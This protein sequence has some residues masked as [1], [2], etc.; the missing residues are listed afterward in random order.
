MLVTGLELVSK[1]DKLCR[2][3]KRQKLYKYI[4]VGFGNGHPDGLGLG[5]GVGGGDGFG[6]GRHIG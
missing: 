3:L 1:L 2:M 6:V 5:L 4:R